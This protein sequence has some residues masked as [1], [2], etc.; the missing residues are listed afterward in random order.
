MAKHVY[1]YMSLVPAKPNPPI[2]PLQPDTDSTASA[3]ERI[4]DNAYKITLSYSYHSS[5]QIAYAY[6]FCTEQTEAQDGI[7]VPAPPACGSGGISM[8]A[9]NL[10]L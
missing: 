5:N 2:T 6:D 4:A 8:Y 3:P 1:Q 9:F 7:G 10:W